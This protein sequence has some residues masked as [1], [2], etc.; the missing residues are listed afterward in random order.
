MA[1]SKTYLPFEN[2]VFKESWFFM[3]M[4][5]AGKF[6]PLFSNFTAAPS[7]L[8]VDTIEYPILSL[9][10]FKTGYDDAT[11][12]ESV[13]VKEVTAK[14]TI[15]QDLFTHERLGPNGLKNPSWAVNK[16][17]QA[18]WQTAQT[19]DKHVLA[20]LKAAIPEGETIPSAPVNNATDIAKVFATLRSKAED[21]DRSISADNMYVF[22]DYTVNAI[23]QSAGVLSGAKS[24][25][26]I[27][28]N[29]YEMFGINTI[30]CNLKSATGVDMIALEFTNVQTFIQEFQPLTV[31]TYPAGHAFAT[32]DFIQGYLRYDAMLIAPK[33]I[34]SFTIGTSDTGK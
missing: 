4:Y 16:A 24:I 9:T 27:E 15:G 34:Y 8:R 13:H 7:S 30:P 19:L 14:M 1:D 32:Q 20:K 23:A 21:S 6:F 2:G 26:G 28:Y 29:V 5:G 22:V 18:S 3:N 31:G 11:G 12:N 10:K 25:N 17:I 33:E